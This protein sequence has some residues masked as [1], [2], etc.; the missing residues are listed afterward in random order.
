MLFD[1]SFI[2]QVRSSVSIVDLIGNYVSLKRSGQNHSGL[3][4][5][6][7]EKT[8]SFLVSDTKQIFK[9]FGCGEGGDVF[10]F[11]TLVESLTFP[12]AVRQLAER[13]GIPLPAKSTGDQ[14]RHEDRQ[15]LLNLMKKA[16]DFF[17]DCLAGPQGAVAREYLESREINQETIERFRIGYAPPGSQLL[18]YLEGAGEDARTVLLCGLS[19]QGDPGQLYD[20]FR[21]RVM[22]PIHDLG[23]NPIAFG[24]RILGEG[25]PKYLNSPET[26][27]Y[28]KSSNLFAL[29]H[30]RFEI[31]KKGFT[32]LV[33]G[34]FDCVVPFQFGFQN[35][36]ASL[37]TSLTAQQI[38]AMRR[39]SRNVVLNYDSD[40]AGVAASIRSIEL[41]LNH[42]LRV[43]VFEL[44]EGVDP[45]TL[46][47]E[48][49]ADEYKS[50]LKSSVNGLD[51]VLSHFLKEQK[52][53]SSPRGKQELVQKM[54][55]FLAKMSD[56]IERSEYVSRVAS[57]IKVQEDL[58]RLEMRKTRGD[59]RLAQL[60]PMRLYEQATWAEM[61]LL[62]AVLE[63]D[64]K[65]YVSSHLDMDLFEGLRTEGIFE[66]VVQLRELKR[67]INILYLRDLLDD[68]ADIHFLETIGIGSTELPVHR[69]G[70]MESFRAL[71]KK[72]YELL[73]RRLQE[74]I[75]SIE[76]TD[77]QSSRIDELL[78]KKEQ[79]RKK[80]E[81]D[82]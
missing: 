27:L 42:G 25:V 77:S 73:S 36:V 49:G 60:E 66:K 21:N 18:R 15:V 1:D 69:E 63:P 23:G 82:L 11:L 57:R 31:R 70:V 80:I 10:K 28:N 16:E 6:H 72:R 56:R 55:P 62:A 65:E 8:P 68:E 19:K 47:L 46:L 58:L 34:Y 30:S 29:N 45:D 7:D 52:N 13:T 75:A 32:I 74:E 41:L 20:R 54:I 9:C 17:R 76:A 40:S 24:G 67:E 44:P 64:W 81:L 50:R 51:F 38:R 35:I 22:F 37:G 71:Q 12:E 39:Y 2:D 14:R 33:E 53:P 78:V 3:C 79:I 26:P 59:R 61:T 4:P 43:N 48:R 5:F